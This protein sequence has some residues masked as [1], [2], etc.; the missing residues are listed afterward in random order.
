MAF[1]GF[2][3]LLPRFRFVKT[4]SGMLSRGGLASSGDQRGLISCCESD[5]LIA[6][7]IYLVGLREGNERNSVRSARTCSMKEE[8]YLG[9]KC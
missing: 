3:N 4:D 6:V 5:D 8:A 2:S 9:P 7:T 1:E